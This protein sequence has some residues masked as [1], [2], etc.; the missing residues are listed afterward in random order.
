MASKTFSEEQKQHLV[1]AQM[2][3]E[4]QRS[5]F[6]DV[7]DSLGVSKAEYNSC[8][9]LREAHTYLENNQ[10]PRLLEC[11]LARAALERPPDLREY[12]I[13]ILTEMKQNKGAN[14]MGMFTEED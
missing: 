8:P 6:H 12:L 5:F 14:S 2:V 7:A 11:L 13:D 4:A 3:S 9:A 10:I 1:A